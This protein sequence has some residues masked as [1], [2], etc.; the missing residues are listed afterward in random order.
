MTFDRKIRASPITKILVP[1]SHAVMR[2]K[3]NSAHRVCGQRFD[4]KVGEQVLHFTPYEIFL[5]SLETLKTHTF[6][7]P[8]KKISTK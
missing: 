1:A 5:R 3:Q 8:D 2:E 4:E 7:F 6:Q